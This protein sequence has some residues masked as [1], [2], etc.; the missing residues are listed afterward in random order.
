MKPE[1]MPESR[2]PIGES[3]RWIISYL[4]AGYAVFVVIFGLYA[5]PD[6]A[7]PAVRWVQAIAPCLVLAAFALEYA[8]R[9]DRLTPVEISYLRF[10]IFLLIL[11]GVAG[12]VPLSVVVGAAFLI[13]TV[14][15]KRRDASRDD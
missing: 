1:D 3:P 6:G 12:A 8:K 4:A 10:A 7:H 2:S 15:E 11:P 5:L 13:W 14:V 9:R